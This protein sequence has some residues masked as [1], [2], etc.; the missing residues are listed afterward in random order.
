MSTTVQNLMEILS[1]KN[2]S[3][4]IEYVVVRTDGSI[5]T[6]DLKASA[7]DMGKILKLFTP[8]KVAK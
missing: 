1:E 2:P 5:V 4:E 7:N 6:M 8:K 3:D